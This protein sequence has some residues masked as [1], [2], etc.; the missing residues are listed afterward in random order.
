MATA[1]HGGSRTWV[2]VPSQGGFVGTAEGTPWLTKQS[3][4]QAGA[5]PPEMPPRAGFKMSNPTGMGWVWV[6][7]GAMDERLDLQAVVL[8]GSDADFNK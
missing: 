7:R 1:F 3:Q 2:S 6:L 4:G 8:L 5:K